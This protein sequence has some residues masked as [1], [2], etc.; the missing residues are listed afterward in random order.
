MKQIILLIT[1]SIFLS[2]IS[3]DDCACSDALTYRKEVGIGY[4]YK[5]TDSGLV[6]VKG[7]E[8]T[9]KQG[10]WEGS[11]KGSKNITLASDIYITNAEGKYQVRFV[12]K[13]CFEKSNGDKEVIYC[14]TY[15][16]HYEKKKSQV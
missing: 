6:P 4:V 16:F 11:L 15:V 12:E 1:A 2:F 7:A 3:C 5:E 8:I 13:G 14:N 10:Y 9:L